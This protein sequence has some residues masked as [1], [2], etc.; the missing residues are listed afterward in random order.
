M[1]KKKIE[2]AVKMILEAIGADLKK[3]DILLTPKRVADMYEEIFSGQFKKPEKE[4]EVILEQKHD[5]IIL[6]RD[7]PLY[8]LCVSRR[9]CVYTKEGAKFAE[10]VKAGDELL[11]FDEQRRDLV[12]TKVEK[13]FRR[14]VSKMREIEIDKGI[15]IKVTEEHPI[16]T[17]DK[18]WV[19]AKDLAIG[20]KVIVVRNRNAIKRRRNLSI[21]K[22]YQL[23]YFIGTVASDG[24]VWRNQVRLEVNDRRFA[25]KFATSIEKSFGL[26]AKVEEIKKPS[27]FLKKVIKQ[28][29]VRV[30]CGE[31]VRIVKD[32]FEGRK[33]A[34]NFP[35]PKVVLE[36]EDIFKGFLHGYIDGDG[37][38]YKDKNGKFKYA[39]IYSYNKAFLED[40]AKVLN[41]KVG[42]Q[43]ENEYVVNIPTQWLFDLKRKRY[44][45]PFISS[46]EAFEFKNYEFAAVKKIKR[47]EGHKYYIV[48][49]FSCFPYNTFIINGV[50]VHNCEHHLLPFIGKAHVAYIPDKKITGLSKIVRVVE[51]LSKRLQVQERL[52][53]EI[54]DVIDKKLK[55][56]GVMVVIEAEHLCMSM[57]GV[58]KPGTITTTS[59]V[60]GIFRKNPKTRQEGLSLIFGR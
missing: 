30:V 20:D 53:T 34:D 32:V 4:L 39:R 40:L 51:V 3:K 12:Y 18:G 42:R 25:E 52:T 17:R 56:K 10:R 13:V 60:R 15:K 16:Y 29:R 11:T 55:P 58:K 50:W 26:K 7:I 49:N 28:Y 45:K 48:Y 38:I 47:K 24:S 8:S 21:K 37:S 22:D 59:V 35:L 44:Y 33:K 43:K 6:L 54:A 36:N 19:K 41:T 23:G 2:K 46:K 14:K 1:D 5:E 57:R 31:L 27:G 9:M